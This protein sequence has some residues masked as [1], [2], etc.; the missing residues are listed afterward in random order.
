MAQNLEKMGH[1]RRIN[2]A[3]EQLEQ[4]EHELSAVCETLGTFI[5]RCGQAAEVELNVDRPD[6]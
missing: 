5:E 1:E 6:R 2:G 4:L 3:H